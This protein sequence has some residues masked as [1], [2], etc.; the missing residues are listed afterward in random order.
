[1]SA[2]DDFNGGDVND[3]RFAPEGYVPTG[4]GDDP[5][6]LAYAMGELEGEDLRAVEA[7]LASDET[8]RAALE[9]LQG[10]LPGVEGALRSSAAAMP[11]L[12]ESAREAISVASADTP[13]FQHDFGGFAR[14]VA[15][16]AAVVL[17]AGGTA[18]FV[19]DRQAGWS[20]FGGADAEVAVEASATGSEWRPLI[21]APR[22][23]E[24]II[25]TKEASGSSSLKALG[26]GGV[27]APGESLRSIGYSGNE[28][29]SALPKPAPEVEEAVGLIQEDLEV[30][31]G[32]GYG[33][34]DQG[35]DLEEML[36]EQ[37]LREQ[38]HENPFVRAD[39]DPMSTFSID[40]DTASYSN[41][42]RKIA[43]GQYPSPF[44]VRIEEFLNYFDYGDEGPSASDEHPFRVGVDVGAA[45]WQ[46]A[47]R[48]VR[49][50]LQGREIEFG[51]RPGANLVFLVDVSGS[52]DRDDKLPLVKKALAML[53]GSLQSNDRVAIVVYASAQGLALDST[54]M[55]GREAILQSLERLDAGGSTNGGAGIQLAYSV[56]RDHFV[57]G[58]VNRVILCTD[59]DFNVGV[60][61]DAALETLIAEESRDGIDLT[62]LGFGSG[63][64]RDEKMER[65]SNRGNGNFAYLDS[66]AEARKVLVTE[67]GGTLQTIAQDVK[68]QVVWNPEVV[69]AARLI[70]YENRMLEHQ[71][72]LDDTQDAGEIGAGHTVTALYEVIPV[73]GSS[74]GVDAPE[75]PSANP[76]DERPV[77]APPE[78]G[79]GRMVTVRLRYKQPAGS[80]STGFE[81]T[82]FD[83]GAAYMDSPESLRF[84]AAVATY[85]M[86]L[87]ESVYSADATLEDARSWALDALGDDR[88]GLRAA[89]VE[90]V[91]KTIRLKR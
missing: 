56:A 37:R 43:S 55:S 60:K 41:V 68:I 91:E 52:M 20:T 88:G 12:D 72:F 6:L 40:V 64:F 8:C 51:E 28:G 82:G 1:M 76:F 47:H 7:A 11:R 31:D 69:Q 42:R 13:V 9:E 83:S 16:A 89:F 81:V 36:L 4:W 59:G 70:G 63:N 67:V 85:G 77:E 27:A 21:E 86:V 71:D 19:V 35:G 14:L 62:V 33:T 48:L 5:R 30:L 25:M 61:S 10:F 15:K 24:S 84:A 74:E 73:G 44:D 38:L 54:P 18:F 32:L 46:P 23:S 75:D 34:G 26:Y 49:I 87:R 58:G 57:K 17:V 78:D 2:Q 22:A 45:P 80:V 29:A 66:E 90:L 65:L 53:T 79:D 39:V 3:G 50:G